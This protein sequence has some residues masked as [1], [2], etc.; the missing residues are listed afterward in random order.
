MRKCQ[1]ARFLAVRATTGLFFLDIGTCLF[2]FR[3]MCLRENH[4]YSCGKHFPLAIPGDGNSHTLQI[5]VISD[6]PFAIGYAS[7][8]AAASQ[9]FESVAVINVVEIV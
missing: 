4:L 8:T 3:R 2:V 5:Q 9:C 6:C 1:L 7:A